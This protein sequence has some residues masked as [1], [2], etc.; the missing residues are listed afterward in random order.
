[1]KIY[2]EIIFKDLYKDE[3]RGG[4]KE[5]FNKIKKN[6]MG[7][8]VLDQRGLKGTDVFIKIKKTQNVK[9]VQLY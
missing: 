3:T 5:V 1:M 9:G 8:I 2:I 7:T 4:C 6:Q